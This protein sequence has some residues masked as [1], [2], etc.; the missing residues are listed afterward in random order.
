VF[1]DAQDRGHKQ[2]PQFGR[3]AGQGDFVFLKRP[4][5]TVSKIAE[6]KEEEAQ[7]SDQVAALKAQLWA[8]REKQVEEKA[9]WEAAKKQRNEA[10]ELQKQL[11]ELKRKRER[12]SVPKP[13]PSQPTGGS[14]GG[15]MVHVSDYGFH[16]DKFEATNREYADF[17][18]S[19]GHRAPE[20]A[21]S[22][23]APWNT[24]SGNQPP[25]G[26]EAH[27]V[28]GVSW[29]DAK[30]Y[31]EWVGKRLPTAEEWQQACQGSD[32]RKY[33]WGSRFLPA[34]VTIFDSA[35]A[36]THGSWDGY[37]NT[38]PVGKFPGGSSPYGARDMVGNVWEWT[39]SLYKSGGSTRVVGGGSF[40]N[41]QYGAQCDKRSYYP[42]DIRYYFNG[43]RC[44]R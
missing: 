10:E 7:Y 44:A 43:F 31:C 28:V 25:S 3:L 20:S 2:Q 30:S 41:N 4:A 15:E 37:D 1:Y 34:N 24:W 26:Y 14:K 39:S 12:P 9:A 18:R 27:P 32:G 33:P 35:N 8:E 13:R 29:Y 11:D 19:S 38:A 6:A 40:A 16:I 23:K 22:G 21:G 42:P 5:S 17:V 36:N